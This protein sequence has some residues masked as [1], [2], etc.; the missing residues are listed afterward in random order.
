MAYINKYSKRAGT[1]AAKLKDNV[2]VM[3]KKRR[4]KVLT[5]ILKKI[6]L[7]KNERHIGGTI[8]VLVDKYRDNFCIGRSLH[9]K[10]V[11][12]P[13]PKDLTGQFVKVKIT[14]ASAWSLK[15]ELC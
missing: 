14:N 7:E 9:Y 3:E 5:Q 4:E 1:A 6:A 13:S 8:E 2:S 12:F 15:G 11:K 10:L